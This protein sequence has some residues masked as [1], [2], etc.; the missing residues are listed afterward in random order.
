MVGSTRLAYEILGNQGSWV[1][2]THGLGHDMNLWRVIAG[3]MANDHRVLI[4]DLR[5]AGRSAK[6]AGPYSPGMLAADLACLLDLA[7][8]G[9]A[10]IVGHSAGGVVSQRFA[11]DTQS[12]LASLTLISTSSEVGQ[13]AAKAW[14]KLA[15]GIEQRGFPSPGTRPD[16]SFSP[17]FAREQPETVARIQAWVAAGD[18]KTYAALARAMS[19][20]NWTAELSRIDA[21]A[22]VLQGAEDQLTPPGGSWILKR[23]LP[24]AK[25]IV[26]PQAGHNLPIEQ[27]E[28]LREVIEAFIAGIDLCATPGG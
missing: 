26:V 17:S 4:W 2:L 16:R 3:Q 28:L 13:R 15:D 9:R 24:R 22:L 7:G 6:P 12:R 19:S 25:L 18:P 5:G 20:Y 23:N 10:L 27:P 1:V 8:V 14:C 21:P 11:L